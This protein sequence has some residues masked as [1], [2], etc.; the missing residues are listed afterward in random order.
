VL[1]FLGGFDKRIAAEDGRAV[2]IFDV[3]LADEECFDVNP[4]AVEADA[5]VP[6]P[7]CEMLDE[8]ATDGFF[9]EVYWDDK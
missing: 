4:V 6:F 3:Y 1:S 9:I 5:V 2:L 7:R 8:V